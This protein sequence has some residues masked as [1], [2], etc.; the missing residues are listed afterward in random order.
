M[1]DA[2]LNNNTAYTQVR[3][4]YAQALGSA[5][6]DTIDLSSFCQ[7]GVAYDTLIADNAYK[8]QFTKALLAEHLKTIYL[9]SD[10]SQEYE[11]PFYEDSEKF[12]AIV[13]MVS[14]KAPAVQESHAW[15]EFVSG[16]STA[17]EYVIFIPEVT[18]AYVGKS[19]TWELPFAVTDEQWN[20][21]FKNAAELSQ[22]NSFIQLTIKNAITQHLADCNRL[23]VCHFMAEKIHYAGSVGA[24]GVHKIDL[25]AL[26]EAETGDA[27]ITTAEAFLADDKC[28]R[29]AAEKLDEYVGYLTAQSTLFNIDGEE[30]FTPKSRQVIEVLQRFE[31]RM[32][33]VSYADAYNMEFVTLPGH[34]TVPYWQGFGSNTGAIDFDNVSAIKVKTASGDTVSQSGIVAFL[35]DKWAIMHTIQSRRTAVTRFDPEALT[36]YY[37]QHKDMRWNNLQMPAIVFT[38]EDKPVGNSKSK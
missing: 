17:G 20:T 14:A 5:A 11:D 19:T 10:Y 13:Q 23:N 2:L 37:M 31:S 36:Q 16:T 32:R 27:T 6:V 38:V 29:F 25:R 30:H 22:F 28:M 26:Y 33:S 4:A 1:A 9:S 21:A 15:Q 34:L 8:D 24:S 7:G 12:G 3:A 35:A 18:S